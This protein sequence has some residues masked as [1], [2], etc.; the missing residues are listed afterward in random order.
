MLLHRTNY[1]TTITD[2]M[3]EAVSVS[4]SV[5]VAEHSTGQRLMLM[6]MWRGIVEADDS[7]RHRVTYMH[8]DT[9]VQ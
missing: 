8:I 3:P 4:V 5:S 2:H 1:S 7:D 9:H 6:L